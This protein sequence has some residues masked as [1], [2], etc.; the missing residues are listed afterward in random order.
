MQKLLHFSLILFNIPQANLIYL[1]FSCLN[2]SFFSQFPCLHTFLL[3]PYSVSAAFYLLSACL[4][5]IF[6]VF[7]DAANKRNGQNQRQIRSH[8]ENWLNMR[9]AHATAERQTDTF[10]FMGQ[11][12]CGPISRFS[13]ISPTPL[14]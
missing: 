5:R 3:F 4:V 9:R 6:C 11:T 8:L 10:I 2:L 7:V 1:T 13:P 12:V 14:I